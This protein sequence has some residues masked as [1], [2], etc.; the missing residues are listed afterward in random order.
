MNSAA[1][2]HLQM[3]PLPPSG[4]ARCPSALGLQC[5]LLHRN[6]TDKLRAKP[7]APRLALVDLGGG[8]RPVGRHGLPPLRRHSASA[9][10]I[11]TRRPEQPVRVLVRRG[12]LKAQLAL[13]LLRRLRGLGEAG[14]REEDDSVPLALERLHDMAAVAVEHAKLLLEVQADGVAILELLQLVDLLVVLRPVLQQAA[15]EVAEGLDE[16]RPEVCP[17]SVQLRGVVAVHIDRRPLEALNLLR[18]PVQEILVEELRDLR[19]QLRCRSEVNDARPV[20]EKA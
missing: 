9:G 17:I 16:G 5:P 10:L 7:V 2:S 19:V 18:K 1:T 8:V 4:L 12:V 3:P 13:T 11:P 15:L 20:P 14:R 6:V